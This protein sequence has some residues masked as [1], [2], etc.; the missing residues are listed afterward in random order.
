[1]T[2]VCRTAVRSSV[3]AVS[4]NVNNKLPVIGSAMTDKNCFFYSLIVLSCPL[5]LSR[6]GQS[7]LSSSI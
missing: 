6:V 5:L 2:P 4:I 3:S 1:M 7:L